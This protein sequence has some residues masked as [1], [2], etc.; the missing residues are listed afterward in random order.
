MEKGKV[1]VVGDRVNLPL[2]RSIGLVTAEARNAGEAIRI[3]REAAASGDIAL[4]IVLKH[5]VSG[6]EDEV[7]RAAQEAGVPVLVLPTPRA[8]AEKINVEKLLARALG[9]G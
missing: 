3:V 7:V 4:V 9:L 2:F 8:P 6:S 1:M 5:I